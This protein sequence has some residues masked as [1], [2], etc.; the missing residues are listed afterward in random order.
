MKPNT[1]TEELKKI[2]IEKQE[3][4]GIKLIRNMKKQ[5]QKNKYEYGSE[6]IEAEIKINTKLN[7]LY[8]QKSE[9]KKL[10]FK[11]AIFTA[12]LHKKYLW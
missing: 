9:F 11:Y 10:T 12:V 8:V 7:L 6:I 1:T 3:L 2:T 5:E 4:I